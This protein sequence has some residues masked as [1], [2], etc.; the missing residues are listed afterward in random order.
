MRS[1]CLA[2]T[3]LLLV[4]QA[5]ASA[6]DLILTEESDESFT[7]YGWAFLVLS[8][9]SASYGSQAKSDADIALAEADASFA[10]Y[11]AAATSDE[12]STYREATVN[13]LNDAQTHEKRANAGYFLAVFLGVSSYYS[14]FP[15]HLPD[16][17]VLVTQRGIALQ[18][19]F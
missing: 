4:W 14:F 12:A 19:R 5:P 6:A 18:Y 9:A 2:I 11:N 1:F 15:E 3:I 13:H 8:L 10:S 16:N 17:T 7:G